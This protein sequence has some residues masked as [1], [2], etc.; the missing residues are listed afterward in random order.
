[1]QV[2][3]L[4]SS[5]IISQVQQL[6]PIGSPEPREPA[7]LQKL[8]HLT[9]NLIREYQAAGRLQG[10]PFDEVWRRSVYLYE[11]QIR[12][13]IRH[14]SVLVTGGEGFVG[15]CLINQLLELGVGRISSIDNARC[16]SHDLSLQPLH[17]Q[18][19]HVTLYAADVRD[20]T[21][22]RQVFTLEKPA[23][24][25][26]LAAIRIPGLAEKIIRETVTSNIFGTQNI[27]QLCEEFKVQ[28]CIFSS[29]GK[30]SRYWTAEVYA[31]TKKVN[32]W[33]LAEAAQRGNV[34]YGMV[35]FTHMLNNSSMC[36]QINQKIQADRPI[37]IHAPERY[38]V[39]QNVEEAVALLL[40][41]LVVSRPKRLRF[42]LVRN[43]GWPIESLEVALYKILQSGKNLPIYF[44]GI[45]PGYEELFFLG[46]V[47]WNHQT[48]I[49]PLV[50]A[51]ETYFFYEVSSSG[52]MIF[53][54]VVPFEIANFTQ[55]LTHL[56][57]LCDSEAIAPI[58]I[59]Q[60]LADVVREVALSQFNHVPISRRL[61]ILK[62]GTN[63][64]QYEQNNRYLTP[65][66]PYIELLLQSL[67]KQL[68]WDILQACK[69]TPQDFERLVTALSSL[70]ALQPEV[71]SLKRLLLQD[72]TSG[73]SR[74]GKAA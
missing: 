52:D 21:A 73:R 45:P 28:Y 74:S 38:V 7:L 5:D 14:R 11:S 29:T 8:A 70:P 54:E 4:T 33:L 50:N 44:Q 69:I 65:Y 49:N 19:T 18:A 2:N 67:S 22:L 15:S 23:I 39:G 35:R 3:A 66:Q 37:N 42:L 43:L 6:V 64:R 51:L 20:L 16:L 9:Q 60:Q 71:D 48:E 41:A 13:V 47:D 46:Q 57:S 1:M 68:S 24:V 34:Q 36:E 53:S 55:Q 56:K 40:N 27:I 25:F 72:H 17:N 62:W 59:K 31:A 10:D 63:L 26:H 32:E 58:A 61:E 30:S 12:D